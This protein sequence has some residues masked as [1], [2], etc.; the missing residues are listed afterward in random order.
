MESG[1]FDNAG[2]LSFLLR[3]GD[4]CP[5]QPTNRNASPTRNTHGGEFANAHNGALANTH[6]G[7]FA[8]SRSIP[9]LNAEN[10]QRTSNMVRQDAAAADG[11]LHA[12]VP[13]SPGK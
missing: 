8:Y 12:L 4:A 13:D 7:E 5:C 11:A 6:R 9:H 3:S 10:S 2:D 1:Y